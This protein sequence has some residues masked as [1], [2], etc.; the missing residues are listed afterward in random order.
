MKS[1]Q[2]TE[3]GH[4]DARSFFLESKSYVNFEMP[5][6][7]NFQELLDLVN[8][9]MSGKKLVDVC[10]KI[11]EKPNYPMFH[12]GVNH[13]VLSNKEGFYSWRPLQI[14][15]PVLYVHVARLI[16]EKN[17]WKVIQKRFLDFAKSSVE[18]IS[19][20]RVSEDKS[21]TDRASLVQFWWEKI[22]QHSIQMAL[23]FSYIF[24]TDITDCYG[25]L[26]T[27]SID[28]ALSPDGKHGSKLRA[29]SRESETTLGGLLDKAIRQ[30][31][32]GQT[33]GI[34]QGSTLM[35]FIAEIV[36][37]YA[38]ECLTVKIKG[39]K[40]KSSSYRILRYRDD[41]RVFVNDPNIGRQIL[42][43]LSEVLLELNM[44]LNPSKTH[45]S[46]DIIISSIKEEKLERILTAPV[47]QRLQR[48]ALRIYQISRK[49]PNAGIIH[50]EL[51]K[52]YDTVTKKDYIKDYDWLEDKESFKSIVTILVMI[53]Y[54]SPRVI[55]WVSAIISKLFE[56]T[57]YNKKEK[58]SLL[59]KIYSKFRDIPHIGAIDIW[60]QR[61][62]EPEGVPFEYKDKLTMVAVE[63][64]KNVELW[65]STWLVDE[66]VHIINVSKISKLIEE[67]R[68]KKITASIEREEV[69]LF[70]VDYF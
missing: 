23:E 51:S 46:N 28:W 29:S 15:H 49:Y 52:Y 67:I 50:T 18:C 59:L 27:H 62:T 58:Q 13:V 68:Y 3:L 37:G 24:K 9:Y 30:M 2:V 1:K 12:E 63:K 19:I 26:Y 45:E 35:D 55:N 16:T 70:K 14:I 54:F 44:R 4:T 47:N 64:V 42:K 48:E 10:K 21:Q 56:Y 36:L 7:F 32:Y 39:S 6:Y 17:S 34:P 25:S 53:S 43:L 5:Y 38:D 41:Y 60:L 11:N 65:D 33:N 22:E 40:I 57:S 20:P 66:L 8:G 31:T 69:E 61:I